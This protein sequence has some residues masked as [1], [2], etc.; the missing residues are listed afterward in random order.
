MEKAPGCPFQAVIP[1]ITVEDITGL[2]GLADTF[3]HVSQNNTTYYIDDK[4]RIIVTWAGPVEANDYNYEE[5]PYNLRSQSVYDFA[6]NR[7]I[8]YNKVGAYR[9]KPLSTEA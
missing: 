8:Y 2:K 6:N 1:S 5:N 9:I 7:E 4:H 3:V